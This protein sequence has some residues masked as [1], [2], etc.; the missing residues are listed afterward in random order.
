MVGLVAAPDKGQQSRGGRDGTRG[1]IFVSEVHLHAVHLQTYVPFCDRASGTT[2]DEKSEKLLTHK[3]YD[4]VVRRRNCL[5]KLVLIYSLHS[6]FC[7]SQR[8]GVFFVFFVSNRSTPSISSTISSW[9]GVSTTRVHRKTLRPFGQRG[10]VLLAHN[11]YAKSVVHSV[12]L[13]LIGKIVRPASFHGCLVN[14]P[15]QASDRSG[16]SVF[17]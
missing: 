14:R 4:L 11:N 15:R 13:G 3:Y 2:F 17:V 7:L 9:G 5:R 10:M 12:S 6:L 1:V 16:R 8:R